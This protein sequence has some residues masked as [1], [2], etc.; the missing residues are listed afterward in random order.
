MFGKVDS[1]INQ[2]SE[3]MEH[4]KR[5][6]QFESF[7]DPLIILFGSLPMALMAAMIPL[8]FGFATINIYTQI[9]L[10]TL[11]GLVSKHGILLT[12]FANSE[13]L[14]GH[15]KYQAIMQAASIRFRP[16]LMT[17]LAIVFGVLPLVFAAGAGAASRFDIG[18]V[19]T[20]GV[21]FGTL[22]TLFVVPVLYHYLSSHRAAKDT[23][24]HGEI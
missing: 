11:A 21:F 20:V 5:P 19:I 22:F 2:Y 8:K 1:Y 24:S 14:Q 10:L 15:S 13:Q 12:K 18:I 17:T 23:Y 9:G 7:K 3:R 4:V 6:M 16:I